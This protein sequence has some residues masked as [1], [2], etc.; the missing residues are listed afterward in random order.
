MTGDRPRRTHDPRQAA[1][2]AFKAA[3]TKP[4]EPI[5]G[6]DPAVKTPH[7]PG[8]T[9]LVSLRIDRDVLDHFQEDGPGWQARINQAL[10]KAAGK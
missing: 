9:E 2:A 3:T 4:L 5:R 1:E 8:A 6:P 7:L 10:R